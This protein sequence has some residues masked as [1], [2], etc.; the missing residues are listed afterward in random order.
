MDRQ[1]LYLCIISKLRF[2]S[3]KCTITSLEI[4]IYLKILALDSGA[5]PNHLGELM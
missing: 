4:D 1:K 2:Y 3:V 5:T